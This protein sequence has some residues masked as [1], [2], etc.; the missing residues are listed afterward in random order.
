M[1]GKQKDRQ[2]MQRLKSASRMWV[3]SV[4]LRDPLRRVGGD[5]GLKKKKTR[6][7]GEVIHSPPTHTHTHTHTYTQSWTT[8]VESKS[9][10]CTKW[11]ENELNRE[12]EER[13][14]DFLE[15]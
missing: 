7:H 13:F 15:P 2:E 10:E 11:K 1:G 8:T 6:S 9:S 5:Y 12:E 14:V 4:N 3:Q